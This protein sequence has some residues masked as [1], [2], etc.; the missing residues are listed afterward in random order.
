MSPKGSILGVYNTHS[1]VDTL[2]KAS[3]QIRPLNLI[4]NWQRCSL[5]ANFLSTF[6]SPQSKNKKSVTS[7]LST[8]VNE[9]LESAIKY[10]ADKTRNIN[11]GFS[12]KGSSLYF[13]I[14]LTSDALDAFQFQKFYEKYLENEGSDTVI[15]ELL[16]ED[17]TS[18]KTSFT[19]GLLSLKQDY[20]AEIGIKITPEKDQPL[21]TITTLIIIDTG[22]TQ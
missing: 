16:E 17:S 22:E 21:Y 18:D 6:Q 1:E 5:T 2:P 19:L 12:T 7:I 9:L 13:E 8:I 14:T 3:M 15:L 4:S 10:S 20:N 11:I